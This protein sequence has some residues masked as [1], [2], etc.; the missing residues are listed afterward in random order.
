[1]S[2]PLD[3]RLKCSSSHPISLR[4]SH[5]NSSVTSC[6]GKFRDPRTPE[7]TSHS[8][9]NQYEATS[10][11]TVGTEVSALKCLSLIESEI[12]E[13]VVPMKQEQAAVKE[14]SRSG[15]KHLEI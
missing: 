3:V 5:Q 13:A 4:N 2:V 15:G 11:R 12:S 9:R 1:M 7:E 10:K 6:L 8:D 14:N